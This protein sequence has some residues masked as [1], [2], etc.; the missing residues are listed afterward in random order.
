[1]KY[2]VLASSLLMSCA[3]ELPG[4]GPS[5]ADEVTARD[6]IIETPSGAPANT[7]ASASPQPGV[8]PMAAGTVSTP[9]TASGTSAPT[10]GPSEDAGLD[11]DDAGA[12]QPPDAIDAGVFTLSSSAFDDGARLPSA[13][14]C[15]GADDS[16]PL[17][18][19]DAPAETKSFALVLTSKAARAGAS[20]HVEWVLWG[21]PATRSSL[22]QGVAEGSQPNNVASARQHSPES[23]AN[24]GFTGGGFTAGGTWPGAVGGVPGVPV[25]VP[26]GGEAEPAPRYRGPC[27]SSEEHYEFTLFALEAG[28]PRG[29]SMDIEAVEEWLETGEHV[30]AAAS[31]SATFP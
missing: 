9:S 10:P 27:G 6:P 14:T 3:L 16:P 19:R 13:F 11:S 23:D 2:V 24:G 7:P 25:G 5:G 15:R 28:A 1:V 20:L 29:G 31:L 30:L 4:S 12:P 22:P 26:V 17:S 18:W 8:Q 21:I